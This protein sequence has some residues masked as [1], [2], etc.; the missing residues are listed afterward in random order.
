MIVQVQG[1]LHNLGRACKQQI[2]CHVFSDSQFL[3][4]G[5]GKQ[6]QRK[7]GLYPFVTALEKKTIADS[8]LNPSTL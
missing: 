7:P 6:T 8:K 1:S 2:T 3:E 5:S 4:R